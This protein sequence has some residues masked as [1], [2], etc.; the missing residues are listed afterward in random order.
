MI[1]IAFGDRDMHHILGIKFG[2]YY[3][4]LI[5]SQDFYMRRVNIKG[6]VATYKAVFLA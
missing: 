2:V 5:F 4:L 1:I 6:P 3:A